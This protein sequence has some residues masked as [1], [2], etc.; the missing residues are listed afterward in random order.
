MADDDLRSRLEAIELRLS[1]VEAAQLQTN[2]LLRGN[3][4]D[5]NDSGLIGKIQIMWRSY[6]LLV[7]AVGGIIGFVLNEIMREMG[8]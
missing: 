6:V 4:D 2:N 7:G 3:A 5:G 1:H 8:H